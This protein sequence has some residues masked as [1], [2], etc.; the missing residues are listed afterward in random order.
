MPAVLQNIHPTDQNGE[1]ET[2]PPTHHDLAR[3]QARR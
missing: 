2:Q 1:G 3:T